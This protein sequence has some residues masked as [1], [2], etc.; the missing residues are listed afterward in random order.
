MLSTVVVVE[1]L[2]AC[3]RCGGFL[4]SDA[5]AC[6]HCQAKRPR[7]R[8]RWAVALGLAGSATLGLTMMACY[9]APPCEPNPRNLNDCKDRQGTGGHDAG[10][11]HAP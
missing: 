8:R 5:V 4:G 9:G 11:D 1:E 10:A 6:P 7:R 3:Y 2:T